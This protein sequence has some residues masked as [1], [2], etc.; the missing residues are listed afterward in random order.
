M[1]DL[2]DVSSSVPLRAD[3]LGV[4]HGGNR[5]LR[6]LP[7]RLDGPCPADALPPICSRR[8]RPGDGTHA[9]IAPLSSSVVRKSN[10]GRISK[11][12]ARTR[13]RKTT[14]PDLSCHV[15]VDAAHAAVA[16]EILSSAD[17]EP[18]TEPARKLEVRRKPSSR[19]IFIA[20]PSP[21][22]APRSNHGFSRSMTTTPRTGASTW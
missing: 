3:V 10:F 13:Q 7:W 21:T 16:E 22:R 2:A 15:R 18:A 14:A 20:S 8:I 19:T 9:S 1:G 11:S 5:S 17:I 12:T 6:N 4:C